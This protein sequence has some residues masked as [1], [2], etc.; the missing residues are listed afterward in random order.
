[1][2]N[3]TVKNNTCSVSVDTFGAELSSFKVDGKE[4]LWQR[5]PEVWPGSA[6]VLFP[7]VGM[8]KGEGETTLI[9]GKPY[10]MEIHGFA[11][12]MDFKFLGM[13]FI[14]K[15]LP[16]YKPF[17]LSTLRNE[18]GF[19]PKLRKEKHFPLFQEYPL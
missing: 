9:D 10:H 15:N 6:P 8:L 17:R 5:D 13:N 1:M 3:Y 16:D 7:I 18:D 19:L 12:D 11:R 4:Y 14:K 2:K